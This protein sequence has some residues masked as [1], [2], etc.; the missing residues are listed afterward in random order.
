MLK[1]GFTQQGE[2][3]IEVLAGHSKMGVGELTWE[4]AHVGSKVKPLAVL[5]VQKVWNNS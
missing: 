3:V 2:F 1:L 4:K 5:R